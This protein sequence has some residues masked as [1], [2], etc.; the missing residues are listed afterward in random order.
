MVTSG[1]P[2]G[3][4]LGP[5]LFVIF[6]ND[7][8]RG[9]IKDTKLYADDTKVIS[10]NHCYDNNKILQEDINRLVKWSEDWLIAFN[11]SKCK[12]MYIGKKN[13]RYEYKLN[14]SVLTETMIGN[15]LGIFISINLEWK[16]HINSAIGPHLEYGATVW[17]PFCKKDIDNLE[18]VQHRATRIEYLREKSYE[19]RL[20]ILELPTLFDRRRRVTVTVNKD[21]AK[22]ILF[23]ILL[24]QNLLWKEY[25][26]EKKCC[27]KYICSS[28]VTNLYALH[29]GKTQKIGLWI[30][31]IS[32]IDRQKLKRAS[33]IKQKAVELVPVNDGNTENPIKLHKICFLCFSVTGRGLS[34]LCCKSQAVKNLISHSEALGHVCSEQIASG[35]LKNKMTRENIERDENFRLKTFGNTLNVVVGIPDTKSKK[36]SLKKLSFD[37]IMELSNTSSLSK[38]KTKILCTNLRENLGKNMVDTNI[39]LQME[40]LHDSLSEFMVLLKKHLYQE[41]KS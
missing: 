18:I 13:P 40:G 19:E 5:L 27:P 24:F 30:A 41:M 35:L 26:V 37:V 21:Y 39:M 29:R 31:K 20:K 7:L 23:Q 17:S 38:R 6:I 10:I 2:Q 34:H 16:Y 14:N 1:V 12:V 25:V 22:D 32:Q 11:E 9:I 4:V 3:S 33:N 8:C 28:C 15:D 36:I